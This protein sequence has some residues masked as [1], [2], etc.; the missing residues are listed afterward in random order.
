MKN[1]A[2]IGSGTMGN[3][4]AHTFALHG[5]NVMLV[6]VNPSALEKALETISRNMDKQISKGDITE[7]SKQEALYRIKT[8]T[9]LI[10]IN[11]FQLDLRDWCH[12]TRIKLSPNKICFK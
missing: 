3:G 7:H 2:V 4:I 12:Y 5:F 10:F 9:S 11:S 1:V 8:A 6:D